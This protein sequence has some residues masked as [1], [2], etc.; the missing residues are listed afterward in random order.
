MYCWK[1]CWN[2]GIAKR[3]PRWSNGEESP[4]GRALQWRRHAAEELRWLGALAR[5]RGKGAA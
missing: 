2:T 1:Y 4:G 3:V 5:R